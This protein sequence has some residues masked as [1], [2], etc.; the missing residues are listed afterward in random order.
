M[1]N[2]EMIKL[3][4]NTKYIVITN[5]GTCSLFATMREITNTYTLDHST[6]SKALN[7]NMVCVCKT[8]TMDNICIRALHM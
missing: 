7:K 4:L 8:K 1:D 2:N 6:I 3:A 5:D